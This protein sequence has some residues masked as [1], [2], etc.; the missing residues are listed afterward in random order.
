MEIK[1]LADGQV[2]FTQQI[3]AQVSH[4]PYREVPPPS[5]PAVELKILIQ[6]QTKELE[7]QESLHLKK[8]RT[9]NIR[10]FDQVDAGFRIAIRNDDIFLTQDYYPAY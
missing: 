10:G 6:R 7:V 4:P 5:Y 9:F 2:L 1:V 8:R 3:S